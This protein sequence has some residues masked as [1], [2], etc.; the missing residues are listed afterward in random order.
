MSESLI[1][2]TPPA[3]A[4][5]AAVERSHNVTCGYCECRLAA[6]GGV[7]RISERVKALNKQEERIE[8]LRSDVTKLQADLDA[9]N[10]ALAEA[11]A[12]LAG[13]QRADDDW[14]S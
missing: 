11:R 12:A 9:A 7:L 10:T 4:P 6:D 2:N 3:P 8:Q 1:P 5:A 13:R 14:D